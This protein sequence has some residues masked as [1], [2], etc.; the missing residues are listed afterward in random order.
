MKITIRELKKLIK[1]EFLLEI[2]EGG[3]GS[4]VKG[5]KTKKPAN[6]DKMDA[7]DKSAWRAGFR[8]LGT[9]DRPNKWQS[10]KKK[11]KFNPIAGRSIDYRNIDSKGRKIKESS[12]QVPQI[13]KGNIFRFIESR[14][15][16]QVINIE[17]KDNGILIYTLKNLSN[18]NEKQ[19]DSIKLNFYLRKGNVKKIK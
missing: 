4:G 19:F 3:K 17:N 6:W 15:D 10:T 8:P 13:E 7:M 11:R 9:P 5:H 2:Q 12:L 18:D 1:E 16:Y 14:N